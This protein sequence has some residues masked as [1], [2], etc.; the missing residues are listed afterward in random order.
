MPSSDPNLDRKFAARD[1]KTEELNDNVVDVVITAADVGAGGTAGLFS[2]QVN[3]QYGFPL[4]KV[5]EFF[6]YVSDTEYAGLKDPNANV[7]LDTLTAGSILL[8]GA[9][10]GYFLVKTDATGLFA[11]NHNNSS[12]ETV[13][14]NAADAEGGVDAVGA[15]VAVRGCV[16][17]DATWS[18]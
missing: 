9:A 10:S 18:A 17:A 2:A 6:V 15:G 3:D 4:A 1:A 7:T 13:Y 8:N 12:D 5:C 16:P 14:Y 11:C